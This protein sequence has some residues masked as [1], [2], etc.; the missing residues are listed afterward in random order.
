MDS[1]YSFTD[2]DW[3]PVA[4]TSQNH[5]HY[6]V[7]QQQAIS[8]DPAETFGGSFSSS[9]TPTPRTPHLPISPHHAP[10]TQANGAY[11]SQSTT[12][13]ISPQYQNMASQQYGEGVEYGNASALDYQDNFGANMTSELPALDTL[14]FSELP[15]ASTLE[16]SA[17]LE[18]LSLLCFRVIIGLSPV[19]VEACLFHIHAERLVVDSVVCFAVFMLEDRAPWILYTQNSERLVYILSSVFFPLPE[20]SPRL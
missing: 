10:Y 19:P 1:N 3:N 11:T 20:Q 18:S 14:C 9:A 2:F 8:P 12:S 16:I 13:P 15:D 5:I 7:R 4:P 6:T 17:H